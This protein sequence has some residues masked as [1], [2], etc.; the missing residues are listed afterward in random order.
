[1]NPAKPTGCEKGDGPNKYI[2]YC[3]DT[4]FHIYCSVIF[5]TARE[6]GG[7]IADT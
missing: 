3:Q 5:S 7:N 2:V 1:M 4:Y 6:K